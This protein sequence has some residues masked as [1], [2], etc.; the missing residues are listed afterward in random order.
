MSH[1]V[2]HR[3]RTRSK[4]WKS[5]LFQTSFRTV[6]GHLENGIQGLKQI[7]HH[8]LVCGNVPTADATPD[9]SIGYI[10]Y[11]YPIV[12]CSSINVLATATVVVV[13]TES[14][15]ATEL[16]SKSNARI[17]VQRRDVTTAGE[18][19]WRDSHR[20]GHSSHRECRTVVVVLVF[21]VITSLLDTV[22]PTIS[23]FH[24]AIVIL[25]PV[26]PNMHQIYG[27]LYHFCKPTE[28]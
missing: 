23:L 3:W 4:S 15:T 10:H 26:S 6:G 13:V 7:L 14:T 25:S 18:I 16:V 21:V 20:V 11:E 19:R 9:Y 5:D 2:L 1:P 17:E 22:C 24:E 8:N 12:P 27:L 28:Q